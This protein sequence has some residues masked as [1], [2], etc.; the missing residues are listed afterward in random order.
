MK[1][2]ACTSVCVRCANSTSRSKKMWNEIKWKQ[3][4]GERKIK[5]KR[6]CLK[7]EEE[8]TERIKEKKIPKDL[9][10]VYLKIDLPVWLHFIYWIIYF[11]HTLLV[12]NNR[13]LSAQ[14]KTRHIWLLDLTTTENEIVLFYISSLSTTT[15]NNI[16]HHQHLT[17]PNRIQR[18]LQFSQESKTLVCFHS[19]SPILMKKNLLLNQNTDLLPHHSLHPNESSICIIW[20][21]FMNQQC[22][23]LCY[24]VALL[25]DYDELNPFS[26]SQ[27]VSSNR[28]SIPVKST[29]IK[30]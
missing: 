20:F 9:L 11:A 16:Q 15:F 28:F 22:H 14:D 10:R 1:I 5:R 25:V 27:H 2:G 4:E 7:I 26:R 21:W 3:I 30:K 8:K 18:V 6:I 17:I 19:I 12:D 23:A 29:E 24:V 13:L